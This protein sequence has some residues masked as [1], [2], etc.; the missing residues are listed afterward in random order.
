MTVKMVDDEYFSDFVHGCKLYF[1]FPHRVET[2]NV[3]L[4]L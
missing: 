3:R 4:V 1:F 2:R